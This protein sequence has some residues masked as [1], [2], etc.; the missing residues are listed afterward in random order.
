[1]CAYRLWIKRLIVCF[2]ISVT[3]IFDEVTLFSLFRIFDKIEADGKKNIFL[4]FRKL[5]EIFG[6]ENRERDGF[7]AE[8]QTVRRKSVFI[9]VGGDGSIEGRLA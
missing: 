3:M 4:S 8:G 9:R 1:M 7:R 2:K 5:A 6:A